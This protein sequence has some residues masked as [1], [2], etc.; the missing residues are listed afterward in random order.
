MLKLIIYVSIALFFLLPAGGFGY[1]V[2]STG[3]F[4]GALGAVRSVF[5]RSIERSIEL[6]TVAVPVVVNGSIVKY[7]YFNFIINSTDNVTQQRIE[8]LVPKFRDAFLN[9]LLSFYN[10]V[11]AKKPVDVPSLINRLQLHVNEILGPGHV[12][13][14]Q[15]DSYLET[16]AVN[17]PNT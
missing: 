4:E 10:K 7:L 1:L 15:L 8:I 5:T 13:T 12:G 17:N 9:D 3:S 6:E 16:Y 2:V 14:L 11:S